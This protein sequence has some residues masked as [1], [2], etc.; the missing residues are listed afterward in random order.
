[1]L[2][3]TISSEG[4]GCRYGGSNNLI[5][6]VLGCRAAELRRSVGQY[7]ERRNR[8]NYGVVVFKGEQTTMLFK[9]LLA[10]CA[11]TCVES[12]YIGSTGYRKMKGM[13]IYLC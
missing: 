4:G 10:T 12:V 2:Q 7:R 6:N 5:S 1:M 3:L 8:T 13:K 9:M 11:H